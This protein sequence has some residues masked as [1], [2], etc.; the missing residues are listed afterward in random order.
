MGAVNNPHFYST[1]S[2]TTTTT[3]ITDA[4]DFPHS[5]LIKSLSQGIRGNYAIKGSATDFDITFADGGSFTTIAV[6]AGKAFRDGKLVTVSALTATNMN[7][8]YNP[9]TGAVDITPVSDDLYLLLVAKSDNTMV[10]RG[11]NSNV[12]KVPD[13]VDGDIPIALIKIA[14][15]SADDSVTTSERQVQYLTTSKVSNDLSIGYDSSGYNEAMSI[16]GTS[17]KTTFHNKVADADIRFVLGDNTADEK[18]EIVTDDDADGDL[19][20]TVTEVFSV[21]GTGD[22]TIAGDLTVSG[23]D[24]FGP[25]DAAL[26]IKSDGDMHF[27]VDTDNDGTHGFKFRDGGNNI[28]AQITEAGL[29]QYDGIAYQAVQN[30]T[31]NRSAGWYTIAK[32]IGRSGGSGGGTGGSNQRGHA[33]FLLKDESSGRHQ[34]IEFNASHMFGTNN[35]NNITITHSALYSTAVV[36]KLRI[37]DNSTYDGCALQAYIADGTNNIV[38]YVKN[39]F[40]DDGWVLV[41]SVA[42]ASDPG[43]LGYNNAWGTFGA[44]AASEV[45]LSTLGLL[46]GGMHTEHFSADD[47]KMGTLE[48][49]NSDSTTNAVVFPLKISEETSGTPANGLGVGIQFEVETSAGNNEIGATMEV[50]TTDVSSG[51]EDFKIVFKAMAA[52]SAAAE[53]LSLDANNV[54]SPTNGRII[55]PG[56]GYNFGGAVYVSGPTSSKGNI[57]FARVAILDVRNSANNFFALPASAGVSNGQLITLK[58]PTSVSAII[59][60]QS[61]DEIDFG[62]T[63]NAM[64]GSANV[65]TLPSAGCVTLMCYSGWDKNNLTDSNGLGVTQSGW[66]VVNQTV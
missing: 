53:M 43:D 50:V 47:A 13:F 58:N 35:S 54:T 21:S 18:F 40:A 55:T 61:G 45:D 56:F 52:G 22:T 6:A 23:G 37:K 27:R 41:D 62:S 65:L 57:S 15:G 8:A 30:M 16:V 25:T 4:T 42:D 20:D 9:G 14:G 1:M 51:S 17:S 24:I 26:S 39:N 63:N 5:G 44:T 46:Q 48:I 7:T 36:T 2:G 28:V 31:S 49:T 60:P 33:T 34:T 59:S 66:F 12:N 32:I 11:V 19:T 38:L 29:L 3:Q 64:I 10:L